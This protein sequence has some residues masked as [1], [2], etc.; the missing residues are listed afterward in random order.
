MQKTQEHPPVLL[1]GAD[2]NESLPIL[3]NL[4]R[5]GVPIAAAAPRRLSMGL[6]S[7]Y[8]TWKLISP[9]P[10]AAPE[11]FVDWVEQTVRGGS[12]P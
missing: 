5:H 2:E 7:R 6:F 8:P 4:H 3:A 12:I 1:L 10:N 9:D 11:K